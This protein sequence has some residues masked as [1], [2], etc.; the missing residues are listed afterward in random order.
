MTDRERRCE[1]CTSLICKGSKMLCHELWDKPCNE[2]EEDGCPDGVTLEAVEEIHDKTKNVKIDHGTGKT[3]KTESKPRTFK[4]SDEKKNLFNEIHFNLVEL[5][6]D[7]V[8]VEKENKLILVE[9]G[10]KK[11]KVDLIEQRK[12]KK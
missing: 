7:N 2:I 12:P 6:G 4:T 1:D 9:I 10:E 5:F 3:V 11:F 8:K